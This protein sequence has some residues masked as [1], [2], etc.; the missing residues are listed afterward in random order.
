MK[1]RIKRAVKILE[2]FLA[3]T[4]VGFIVLNLLL[5]NYLNA[6]ENKTL[7][8]LKASNGDF[9]QTSHGNIYYL[10]SE[11]KGLPEN[12]KS[13]VIFIHGVTISSYSFTKNMDA[14]SSISDC[15]APDLKGYGLSKELTNTNLSN[16][17]Q[18]DMILEFADKLGIKEFSLI[19][20]SMGGGIS[21]IVALKAE[22]R[23]N[24]LILISPGNPNDVYPGI[25]FPL[26]NY[27]IDPFY[28]LLAT[29]LNMKF[30]LSTAYYDQ[31][32]LTD[33]IVNSYFN[34]YKVIGS[35]K[36]LRY[37]VSSKQNNTY[38]PEDINVP[39]LIVQGENDRI[40]PLSNSEELN[41]KIY[42]S[43]LE[44]IPNSGHLPMEETSDKFNTLMKD[45]LGKLK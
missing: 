36:I 44:I 42:L 28:M 32:L 2:I 45:F 8:N 5:G 22:E 33:D 1:R 38:K 27:I 17:S 7:F 9:I 29:P 26:M 37:I 30:I 20:H 12:K 4:F 6:N 10:K 19:G 3:L 25:S 41:K 16:E 21:E 39:T 11:Y 23:V 43:I 31:K 34:P 40:I 35:Y 13:A 24:G 15:Y 14:C 18:A